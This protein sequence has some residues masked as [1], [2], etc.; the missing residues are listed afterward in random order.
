MFSKIVNYKF[1]DNMLLFM[2]IYKYGRVYF[3][4]IIPEKKKKLGT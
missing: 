2:F 4:T 3:R 1:Q